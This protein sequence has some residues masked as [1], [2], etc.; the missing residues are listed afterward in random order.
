MEEKETLIPAAIDEYTDDLTWE[1]DD[2]S[3]AVWCNTEEEVTS[4]Q[5]LVSAVLQS[6]SIDDCIP[7]SEP[8]E[9]LCP[10]TAENLL[11][12]AFKKPGALQSPEKRLVNTFEEEQELAREGR[13]YGFTVRGISKEAFELLCLF[14]HSCLFNFEGDAKGWKNVNGAKAEIMSPEGDLIKLRGSP[15]RYPNRDS[16]AVD[17]LIQWITRIYAGI[18]DN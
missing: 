3:L 6:E 14:F 11:K 18:S 15:K 4:L 2:G 7:L 5:N 9:G 17:H 16:G 12:K 13:L 1:L 8:L 10:I